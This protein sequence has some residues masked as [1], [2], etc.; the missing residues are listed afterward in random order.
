VLASQ[1]LAAGWSPP[2]K[3][4]SRPNTTAFPDGLIAPAG[5]TAVAVYETC[6][7]SGTCY[8]VE[9]RRTA[10]G[11]ASWDPPVV[12]SNDGYFAS[13]GGR[14]ANADVA[15]VNNDN[16]VRYARSRNGGQS[17]GRARKIAFAEH[18]GETSIARGPNGLVAIGWVQNSWTGKIKA[19]ISTDGGYSFGPAQTIA[20]GS[21]EPGIFV[22]VG[23]GV[24]HVAYVK[25]ETLFVRR[26]SDRGATWSTPRKI[27]N[28]MAGSG[29]EAFSITADGSDAYVAY[30]HDSGALRYR[31][32]ADKGSTWSSELQLLKADRYASTPRLALEGGVLR[33]VFS[34]SN[35]LFYRESADGLTWSGR[36]LVSEIGYGAFVGFA[37]R[38]LVVYTAATG[39]SQ[40]E[41]RSRYRTP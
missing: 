30:V 34:A 22:A 3:V 13:I 39:V 28:E 12:L 29:P 6:N 20:T 18:P 24:V 1:V 38:P 40:S 2:V 35:G 16:I 7:L 36:E 17:F 5:S 31:H 26:S 23:N 15:W 10:D 33:A 21:Y 25:D 8:S 4:L 19:R 27:S 14:G 9:V 32:S 37:G 11:G 41:V